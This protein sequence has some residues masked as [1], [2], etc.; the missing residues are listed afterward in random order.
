MP[1]A[2]R[3]MSDSS[4]HRHVPSLQEYAEFRPQPLLLVEATSSHKVWTVA[5][6]AISQVHLHHGVSHEPERSTA[7]Q[8]EQVAGSHGQ[9]FLEAR[10]AALR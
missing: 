6:A 8:W 3:I 4:P 10:P 5:W 7:Q 2:H 9:H 1:K